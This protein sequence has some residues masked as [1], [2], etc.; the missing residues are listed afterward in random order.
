MREFILQN[1]WVI[2]AIIAW[3]LPW[4]GIALWKAARSDRKIWFLI[5]FILNTLAILDII[6][7]VFFDEEKKR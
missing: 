1:P 4:K 5:L 3:T 7:I 2:Y 6:F